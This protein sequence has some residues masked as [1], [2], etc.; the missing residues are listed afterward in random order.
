V[1][2]TARATS[3]TIRESRPPGFP[4]VNK[5][6]AL[7]WLPSLAAM[8]LGLGTAETGDKAQRHG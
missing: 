6:A 7:A 4:M 8:R 2:E 3:D 5:R 1:G